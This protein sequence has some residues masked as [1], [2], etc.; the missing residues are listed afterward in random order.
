MGLPSRN[1]IY[2]IGA[3]LAGRTL[4]HEIG[5]KEIFGKVVALLDDDPAKIGTK[6][7]SIPILGPIEVILS[8]LNTTPNDE[9]LI[10]I[11]SGT[12]EQISRIYGLLR[13]AGFSRI[14][15]LPSLSQ[16]L[17]GDAHLIQA[18][19]INPEDL[20]P[21]IPVKI[22][23]KESLSYVRSRRV[24]VTG[25]GGSIGSELARQLLYGGAE[26]LYLFALIDYS[27]SA[28]ERLVSV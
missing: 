6:L 19:E 24:L 18:R 9:A 22:S 23:L 13:N 27:Y 17:F 12:R 20:L 15:I 10:A 5:E 3:G 11:P 7:D 8:L 4:T 2:I 26:R 21:R 14:R 1:Q 16:I 28:L 25:A